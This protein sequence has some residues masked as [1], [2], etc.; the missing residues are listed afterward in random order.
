M[1]HLSSDGKSLVDLGLDTAKQL[2][3]SFILII[4]LYERAGFID[5]KISSF[6]ILLMSIVQHVL[7][8]KKKKDIYYGNMGNL[9][10]LI[11][12][13]FLGVKRNNQKAGDEDWDHTKWLDQKKGGYTRATIHNIFHAICDM[14]V[15][16]NLGNMETSSFEVCMKIDRFAVHHK[17]PGENNFEAVYRF[18]ELKAII[19]LL[20]A[21]AKWNS[22]R[23]LCSGKKGI[24][25][26]PALYRD[27]ILQQNMKDNS[28]NGIS[29][30]IEYK[31]HPDNPC[32]TGSNSKPTKFIK[33]I[34]MEYKH[35]IKLGKNFSLGVIVPYDCFKKYVLKTKKWNL[36]DIYMDK[37]SLMQ[38]ID[39]C[40][41]GQEYDL[42]IGR[43][44]SYLKPWEHAL[45][46]ARVECIVEYKF[47]CTGDKYYDM[48]LLIGNKIDVN[49]KEK[50]LSTKI[51][52]ISMDTVSFSAEQ[53]YA[54]VAC[55]HD[56]DINI[57][58]GIKHKWKRNRNVRISAFVGNGTE[59]YYDI[60]ETLYRRQFHKKK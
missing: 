15:F 1:R 59:M 40:K 10:L 33:H 57:C 51:G 5:A 12:S 50:T 7:T 36:S 6:L 21:G 20:L 52:T 42:L 46:F 13:K 34:K 24:H 54:P 41:E 30:L 14:D 27:K 56:C 32:F 38:R 11:V 17:I 26:L 37:I 31:L 58:S 49:M 3:E 4:P 47:F 53:L 16:G 29:K 35:N 23:E 39:W 44:A 19:L 45:G 48:V 55:Y 60:A 25:Q 18:E 43:C 28:L 9:W 8:G 2:I 22:Q